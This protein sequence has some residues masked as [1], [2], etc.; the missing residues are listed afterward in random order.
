MTWQEIF[1]Y[2]VL[3]VIYAWLSCFHLPGHM[4][5]TADKL[6][7]KLSDDMEWSLDFN[8]FRTIEHQFGKFDID[9][10]ASSKNKQTEILCK[11]FA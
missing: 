6:S 3:I 11:F 9:L 2:G 1:G 5:K 10:F 4:N 7:R 8:C